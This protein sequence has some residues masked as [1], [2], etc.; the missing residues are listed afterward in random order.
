MKMGKM[1]RRGSFRVE[2]RNFAFRHVKFEMSTGHQSGKYIFS[3]LYSGV[4]RKEPH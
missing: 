2:N 3:L 1:L 4:Q